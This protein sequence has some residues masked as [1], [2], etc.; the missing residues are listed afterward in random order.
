M[1]MINTSKP[2]TALV[3]ATR[4]TSAETWSSITTS[5]GTETRTWAQTISLMT[6]TSKPT[7]T[8]TNTAKPT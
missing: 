2:T 1:G 3:N 4:A 5:W 7:T 6:G 8:F